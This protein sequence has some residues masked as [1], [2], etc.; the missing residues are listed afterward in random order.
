MLISAIALAVVIAIALG[1]LKKKAAPPSQASLNCMS[2]GG[3]VETRKAADGKDYNICIFA[4]KS[5]CEEWAFLNGQCDPGNIGIS[6][7][8]AGNLAKGEEGMKSD[9]WYFKYEQDG[10]SL[11][12]AELIFGKDSVCVSGTKKKLCDTTTLKSSA[13]VSIEGL[14]TDGMII[15]RKLREM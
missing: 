15:V 4:N 8:K 14:K 3:T 11:A 12:S 5:E 6:F 9:A 1:L 10:S 2:K 13:R 7:V